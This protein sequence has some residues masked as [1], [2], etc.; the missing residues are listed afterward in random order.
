MSEDELPDEREAV[1]A[2]VDGDFKTL[3]GYL[4]LNYHRPYTAQTHHTPSHRTKMST[5][6]RPTWDPA[7]GKDIKTGS[8][9]FSARDMASQTKL[10]FRYV[11][12]CG[13]DCCHGSNRPEG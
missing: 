2:A 5:A 7:Q 6:H 11:I 1:A 10:K 8:R 4:V 9:Q 3:L 12:C 13:V